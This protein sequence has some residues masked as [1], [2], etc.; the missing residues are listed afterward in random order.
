MKGKEKK[1]NQDEGSLGRLSRRERQVMEIIY[2]QQAA[3][4]MEVKNSLADQPSYSAVRATLRTLEQKRYI[5]HECRGVRYVFMP[6]VGRG[7][8]KRSIL[9]KILGVF[10]NNSAEEVITTLLGMSDSKMSAAEL[11]RLAKLID[12]AREEEQEKEEEGG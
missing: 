5:K 8:V 9:R 4:A 6:T 7:S 11:D 12:K 2:Q 1:Q 3:T 10:F